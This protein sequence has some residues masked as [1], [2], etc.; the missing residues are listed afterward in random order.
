MPIQDSAYNA[1]Y[2]FHDKTK[3]L[4]WDTLISDIQNVN[5]DKS[6]SVPSVGS[7]SWQRGKG[8]FKKIRT[9]SLMIQVDDKKLISAG[10]QV[11]PAFPFEEWAASMKNVQTS[12][13]SSDLVYTYNFKVRRYLQ[14]IPFAGYIVEYVFRTQTQKRFKAM[15]NW[16]QNKRN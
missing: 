10:K 1:F 15:S 4:Q 6:L 8:V 7:I 11:H 16:L 5:G 2:G 3:R 12:E 13:N 9:A 14:F